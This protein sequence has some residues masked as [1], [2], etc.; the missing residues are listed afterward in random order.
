[1]NDNYAG[2]PINSQQE[3]SSSL[4]M[5]EEFQ[6]QSREQVSHK[7][8]HLSLLTT[9]AQVL[10]VLLV[11]YTAYISISSLAISFSSL[12]EKD[13][14]FRWIRF[15]QFILS[16][17]FTGTAIF[18]YKSTDAYVPT[19]R[20]KKLGRI[21]AIAAIILICLQFMLTIAAFIFGKV[22]KFL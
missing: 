2:S 3:E 18:G 9:L 12:L 7:E 1:M 15:S 19:S 16:A 14:A 13:E 11:L 21:F 5:E 8:R 10:S 4:Q 22:C 6:T 20:Q 17:I